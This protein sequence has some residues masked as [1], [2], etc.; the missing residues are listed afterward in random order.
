MDALAALTAGLA[1]RRDLSDGDVA[2]AAAALVSADGSEDAKAAFLSASWARAAIM[3]AD[4]T[5]P[6]W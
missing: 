3:R 6:A 1:A 4:S 5:S 2:A